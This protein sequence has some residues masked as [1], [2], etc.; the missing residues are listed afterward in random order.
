MRRFDRLLCLVMA[1]VS[2]SMVYAGVPSRIPYNKQQLFL[3]GANL[4]WVSY[5]QD[6]G[7]GLLDTVTFGNALL[8]MHDH[9]GNVVRWW[10]HTTGTGTPEFNDSGRVIGPGTN[11]IANL[12]RALDI[13]RQR[14]IGVVMSLWSFGMMD[15]TL[16]AT[17]LN[18]N[19]LLLN[20]TNYTRSY[21]NN[22][23]I[24]MV[25]S[26]KGHPAIVAWEIFNEPEGMSTEFGWTGYNHVPMAKI[27]RFINLCA[28]A[29]HR[30]DST[31]L[32]TNGTVSFQM[33]T[34]VP[35]ATVKAKTRPAIPLTST[36]MLTFAQNLKAKYRMSIST[37]EIIRH[38]E[39]L[40]SLQNF[41]YYLDSRLISA[42][43]DS[44]GTLDFY[45]AHFYYANNGASNSPF[46]HP[47]SI[48]GL[49]KPIIIGEFP[50]T[51]SSHYGLTHGGMFDTLYAAGY[52]GALPWSWTDEA[53]S[54]QAAMLDGMQYMWNHHQADVKVLGV[55]Q[56][57]PTVSITSPP[58]DTVYADSAS[59]HLV[60]AASDSGSRVVAVNFFANNSQ[61]G[62]A[63]TAPFAMTWSHIPSG[64]YALTATAI[65]SLGH[66]RTS[67]P[68]K[69]IVGIP[70]MIN[71]EAETATYTGSSTTYSVK[72]DPLA[73]GGKYLDIAGQDGTITWRFT[74]VDTSGTYP[75]T[76]GFK[77]NYASPKYQYLLVNGVS[78]DT[79]LFEGA[80]TTT[81]YTTT[82]P[83]NLQHG[84]DS[85]Q[86]GLFWGWMS[87]DYL[88][89]PTHVLTSVEPQ[90]GNIPLAFAL[91]QN[92]P[93]PFNPS[94]T[95]DYQIPKQGNVSLK[96]YDI[97]GR[98]V[99]TLVNE[100]QGAGAYKVRF[101][102]ST[103]AS[104]VYF[105]RLQ[106]GSNVS[107]M[108]MILVK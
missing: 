77:L 24:P 52:A 69:I 67:S 21:I 98:L 100:V 49:T 86:I 44:L 74:N 22:A 85:I 76:F 63:T 72:S 31:A 15:N 104:G 30:A 95:I 36:E 96:V 91:H 45:E 20:D 46:S 8:Q 14:N 16:G 3:S 35:V 50:M 39:Y 59:V 99:R 34:D 92:Y 102:A 18:R 60:A 54:T 2:C 40:N 80:S 9:G 38:I 6:I 87:L 26:L 90:P 89:V 105:Y 58:N 57:W 25:D 78:V 84:I 23:L 48:W 55:G 106:A 97:V 66:Y 41:N 1:V 82:V 53:F 29:I 13:A 12:R 7:P 32:I 71:L 28:G 108:K 11:A 17:V 93:N 56:Y 103:L 101:D 70:P 5:A 68:V 4:A 88:G 62:S 47:A 27:Q 51:D 94:T 65:D 43:G 33:L 79:V 19:T 64:V 73:S 10:L 42:G 81:W 83:V 37:D 107:A 61:I 75:I